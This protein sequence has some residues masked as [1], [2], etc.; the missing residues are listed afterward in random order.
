MLAIIVFP[1]LL[2]ILHGISSNESKRAIKQM[3]ESK[4]ELSEATFGAGCFWCIEAVYESMQGV[5]HVEPGYA[6]GH[7]DSPNYR[8]VCDGNT[9]HIEVVR[10]LFDELEVSFEELLDVFWK[11]HD[12]T[13]LDR[14]GMDVGEQYKSVIFYHSKE[15]HTIAEASKAKQNALGLWD[16]PVVTE[17]RPIH[18]YHTAED[19]HHD[20]FKKNPNQGYCRAVVAPKVDKFRKQFATQLKH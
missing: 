17:I 12:P 3:K 18:N 7:H 5:Y 11:V 8:L 14:Q 16:D 4:R 10:I 2:A 15:Q 1:F 6:G 20:Y 13:T 9:G 19:Y